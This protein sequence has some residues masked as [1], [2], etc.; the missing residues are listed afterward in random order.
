MDTLLLTSKINFVQF[1]SL[2]LAPR[3]M[4]DTQKVSWPSQ[5]AQSPCRRWLLEPTPWQLK[6]PLGSS[7][8][9]CH[10]PCS[11]TFSGPHCS[12]SNLWTE[13]PG[14]GPAQPV[15]M[16]M[17]HGA[18]C[19]PQGREGQGA[20]SALNLSHTCVHCGCQPHGAYE[21]QSQV[22]FFYTM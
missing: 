17:E 3:L 1:A 12:A 9:S 13:V 22:L 4:T 21:P 5:A 14:Q 7:F 10:F 18:T 16:C 11:R 20:L 6:C 15:C 2:A 8:T 19:P